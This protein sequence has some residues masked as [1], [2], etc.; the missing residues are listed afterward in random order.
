M[1]RDIIRRTSDEGSIVEIEE[2]RETVRS[3]KTA[4]STI[5]STIASDSIILSQELTHRE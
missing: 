3:V 5:L 2:W 1:L 4:T